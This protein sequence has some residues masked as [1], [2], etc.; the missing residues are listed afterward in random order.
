[1]L[2]EAAKTILERRYLQRDAEGKIIETP[3]ELFRRVAKA[4]AAPEGDNAEVIAE[5]FY[6]MMVNM[7]FLPNSPTLMNAGLPDGQLNACFVLPIEDSMESIFGTLRDAA[8]I[9]KTGGGTGFPFSNLRPSNSVVKS[10]GGI[11]SGPI[12]FMHAYNAATET[13]KQ[14]GK[15]R[16]ANMAMLRVDHPNIL[17]FIHCKK[18][19]TVLNNFNVSVAVTKAFM[20]ALY[21]NTTYDLI[22]PRTK[23]PVGTL[24]AADV[25]L[26]IITAAHETGEPGVFFIDEANLF[27]PTPA[28][29]LYEATNPCGEQP[30][31]NGESCDLGSINLAK[32]VHDGI[33]D[34]K[35]LSDTVTKAVMFL[36][37]V[38]DVTVYPLEFIEKT[39]KETR[40]IGL[41]VMGWADM[42]IALGIPYNSYE[43]TLLAESLMEF[44]TSHA[45]K[46]SAWIAER[47]GSF[48]AKHMSIWKDTPHMRNATVTTI[49]PTG[50]ISMLAEVSSGIEPIFGFAY[51]KTVMDNDT[52]VY[53][54]PALEDLLKRL[55]FYHK[56]IVDQIA[57]TGRVSTVDD[58]PQSIKKV[59]VC[60]YDISAEDHIKMQAAFQLHTDNAISKT[61][62]FPSTATI[63]DFDE[64][65]RLAYELKC[66]GVTAYRD[67]SR[68]NQ[69]LNM[70][71]TKAAEVVTDAKVKPRQRAKTTNGFTD[72]VVT[73]CGNLYTTVNFDEEGICEVFTNTSKAGGC[74]SQSEASARLA[75]LALRANVAY[76]DIIDQLKGIRCPA[77]MRNKGSQ[78]LSCPD[79]IARTIERAIKQLDSPVVLEDN[80]KFVDI[81]HHVDTPTATCPECHAPI[82]RAEG[83]IVCPSC[84]YS[85]CN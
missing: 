37:N 8:L 30:L 63:K 17:D 22:D 68:T 67:G 65:Y 21:A 10:T 49:A 77:A 47:K 12:S 66:K 9:H 4:V 72:K 79:A 33:I 83:C 41:G 51:T 50:T 81:K 74:Q 45:R 24:K 20:D 56:D 80:T 58:I 35:K 46:A 3:E 15:R 34:Y 7:E 11:A 16:G 62:N 48:P 26:E 27:N 13:V 31:R 23:Q 42:L 69:V 43:A 57:E 73:G 32:M 60:A 25:W 2:T 28:L 38:I 19:L 70:G 14:G 61:I 6:N 75:T 36:D 55:G 84:G 54:N 52:F 71:S 18:D 59:F 53:L 5:Q 29:G 40:K 76:E 85:K 39:S 64:G 78:C 82:H 44:I 1:M